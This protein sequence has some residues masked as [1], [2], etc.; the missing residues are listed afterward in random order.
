MLPYTN[1]DEYIA[2]FPPQ[3]QTILQKIRQ[4]IHQT[5]PQATESIA[6]GIPTFRQPKNLIH[7]AAYKHHLS[8]YPIPHG[9]SEFMQAI[10]PHIKGKGT[11]QFPFNQPIPWNLIKKIIQLR[12]AQS[13]QA[14][15]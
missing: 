7:F 9:D 3:V 1:I 14:H 10:S 11:L 5:V 15:K 13:L 8:L 2:N 12:T 6:Y 4:I